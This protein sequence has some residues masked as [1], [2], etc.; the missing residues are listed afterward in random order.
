MYDYNLALNIL[1]DYALSEGY[2]VDLSY[3]GISYVKFQKKTLNDPKHIKIQLG[4]SDEIRCYYFL[5]ELGHHSLRKDW[6]SFGRLLPITT[7][8]EEEFL[9]TKDYKYLYRVSY[10]MSS[11]E[12]EFM[13]WAEGLKLAEHLGIEI[14]LDVWYKLKCKCLRLYVR[15]Y[16]KK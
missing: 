9:A 12:E 5:H 10:Y 3:T 2:D 16:A 14:D 13:A 8:A 11:L 1:T 7:K 4:E 15:Y 6:E